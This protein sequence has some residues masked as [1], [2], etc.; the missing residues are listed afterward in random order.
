MNVKRNQIIV[1]KGYIHPFIDMADL[2]ELKLETSVA[3]AKICTHLNKYPDAGFAEYIPP[4]AEIVKKPM[5]TQF[6]YIYVK[7]N[8]FPKTTPETNRL[9]DIYHEFD[10][11]M[12]YEMKTML[13]IAIFRSQFK[14]AERLIK[15]KNMKL[16]SLVRSLDYLNSLEDVRQKLTKTQ[17]KIKQ[18]LIDEIYDVSFGTLIP[19]APPLE[20]DI[21]I[22]S[23]PPLEEQL[24][25]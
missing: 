19:S 3:V 9:L 8:G 18:V 4:K 7:E 15:H 12:M 2:P 25:F 11:T 24:S 6:Y 22:P 21:T 10:V 5:E 23:A 16:D 1:L 20:E 14:L 13:D 17:E